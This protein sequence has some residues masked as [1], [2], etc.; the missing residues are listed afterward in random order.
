MI[1]EGVFQK[2]KVVTKQNFILVCG[3]VSGY[4]EIF[5]IVNVYGPQGLNEKKDLW[6]ELEDLKTSGSG[7]WVYAGDFNEVRN[8][9]ERVKSELNVMGATLFNQFIYNAQLMEYNMGGNPYT[10]MRGFGDSYSKLDRFLVCNDFVNKWPNA[11]VTALSRHLFDHCPIFLITSNIDFGPSPFRFYSSWLK[12][13]GIN[14]VVEETLCMRV[15]TGKPDKVL[16]AKLKALKEV[17]RKWTKE[18]KQKYDLSLSSLKLVS[19][20]YDKEASNRELSLDELD[21]WAAT[22]SAEGGAQMGR[23]THGLSRPKDPI[24]PPPYADHS[25]SWVTIR[26]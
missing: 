17:L 22:N 11:C 20:H 16:A 6:V 7:Y 18:Q 8:S 3:N 13:Q 21:D 4:Q 25:H 26:P 14:E 1:N 24:R 10:Y 2:V 23:M 15:A 9:S 12:F 5:N 19:N